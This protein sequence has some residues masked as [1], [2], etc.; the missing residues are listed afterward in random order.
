VENGLV[1]LINRMPAERYR[2]AIVCIMDYSYFRLRIQRPDVEC[3]ALHKPPGNV[4]GF[5][6][7]GHV[8]TEIAS[9]DGMIDS[10]GQG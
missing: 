6:C 4:P 1:N 5:L 7:K 3:Y 2:H 8:G 9:A 10:L